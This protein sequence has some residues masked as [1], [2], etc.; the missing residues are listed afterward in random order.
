MKNKKTEADGHNTRPLEGLLHEFRETRMH[1]INRL[2]DADDETVAFVSLHPRL[3]QPM[4]LVDMAFFV[5]EHDDHHLAV[6]RK[7]IDIK[8]SKHEVA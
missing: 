5:A 7:L 3:N 6:I 2:S 4:R 1:F 8:N